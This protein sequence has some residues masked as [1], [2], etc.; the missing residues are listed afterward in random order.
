M[1]TKRKALR[2]A[3]KPSLSIRGYPVF[4][5]APLA[6]PKARSTPRAVAP[7]KL[8]RIESIRQSVELPHH[9]F[10]MFLAVH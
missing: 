1:N 7:A 6:D 2:A 3:F 9:R 8:R 4:I 10:L 5:R